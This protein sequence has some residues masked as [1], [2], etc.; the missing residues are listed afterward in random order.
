[1]NPQEDSLFKIKSKKL[2]DL[3][4]EVNRKEEKTKERKINLHIYTHI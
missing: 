1:M 2:A 3:L 4:Q